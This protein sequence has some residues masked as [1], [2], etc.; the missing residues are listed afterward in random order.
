MKVWYID[1]HNK[2][3]FNEYLFS[4]VEELKKLVEQVSIDEIL[5]DEFFK[6]L[7]GWK[8]RNDY[9]SNTNPYYEILN[10]LFTCKRN[11]KSFDLAIK[12]IKWILN[13]IP[14]LYEKDEVFIREISR[15]A[16]ILYES[17]A[18]RSDGEGISVFIYQD[19]VNK[20]KNWCY[21]NRK[22]AKMYPYDM[23]FWLLEDVIQDEKMDYLTRCYF[24]KS[25]NEFVEPSIK[26]IEKDISKKPK[27]RTINEVSKH[28]IRVKFDQKIFCI[29]GQL[30]RMDKSIVMEKI[31]ELGGIYE[32]EVTAKTN[33]LVCGENN[34]ELWEYSYIGRKIV[35]G[36]ENIEKGYDTNIIT[37]IRLISEISH[38]EN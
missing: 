19:E 20:L 24:R 2:V 6:Q 28:W 3:M 10:Y 9:I 18:N 8:I 15:L 11:H 30:K 32:D 16:E 22:L 23:Y 34:N 25:F 7:T 17:L 26:G 1:D 13:K 27:L 35:K 4:Q 29:T 14:A 21:D 38:N 33:Y 36:L 12:E 31:T 37:E 5:V